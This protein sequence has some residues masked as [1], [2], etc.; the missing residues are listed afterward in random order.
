MIVAA[1]GAWGPGLRLG[2]RPKTEPTPGGSTGAEPDPEQVVRRFLLV[3]SK[4]AQELARH[5][6]AAP[7]ITLPVIRLIRQTLLG[8]ETGQVHEAEVLLGGLLHA[9]GPA[10]SAIDPEEILY[11]FHDGVRQAARYPARR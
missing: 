9:I 8:G 2:I 7:I 1:G 11:D 6:A 10:D 4:T 3:G 5:L